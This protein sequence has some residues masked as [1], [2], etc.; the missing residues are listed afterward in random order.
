[1]N[2]SEGKARTQ[3][4]RSSKKDTLITTPSFNADLKLYEDYRGKALDA[5]K[6]LNDLV[7]V[8]GS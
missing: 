6:K 2:E 3:A 5:H 4:R 1:M 8:G 7:D